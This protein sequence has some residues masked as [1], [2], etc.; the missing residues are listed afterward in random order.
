MSIKCLEQKN[1]SSLDTEASM[2]RSG[3]SGGLTVPQ[4]ASSELI[5]LGDFTPAQT[6]HQLLDWLTAKSKISTDRLVILGVL[7][8]HL[9][10]WEARSSPE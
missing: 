4:K 9:S 3:A 1:Q 7:A 5:S 10:R 8:G 2:R 6:A